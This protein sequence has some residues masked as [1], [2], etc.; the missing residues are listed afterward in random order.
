MLSGA[1]VFRATYQ[2]FT[3]EQFGFY[4][5]LWS[6]FGYSILLDFGLGF[7]TQRSAAHFTA[8]RDITRLNQLVTTV[9]WSFLGLSAILILVCFLGEGFFLKWA[10]VKPADLSEFST[11][12]RIFFLLS[13]LSFAFGI[14]PEVLQGLQRTDLVN[15]LTLV[16][17][18]VNLL[19][20]G[21]GVTEHWSF[22][23]IVSIAVATNL[24]NLGLSVAFVFLLVQGFSLH[25]RHF[26]R[27]RVAELLSFSL[28][29]YLITFTNLIL[30]RTDQVLI[31]FTLG[32]AA[33]ALYQAGYKAAEMFSLLATQVHSVLSSAA[34]QVHAQQDRRTLCQLLSR[35]TQL[36]LFFLAPAYA[37]CALYLET[38][39]KVLTGLAQ[40][41]PTTL[42][43]G[44]ILLLATFSGLVT[45]GCSRRVL[46]MCGWE[47]P[48]LRISLL[49]AVLNFSLSLALVFRLGPLGV[50]IG[51]AI[52]SLL[53]GWFF[54][55]PLSATFL[56]ISAFHWL[57]LVLRPILFPV[58]CS[59]LALAALTLGL[60]LPTTLVGCFANGVVV[61]TVLL[62]TGRGYL[63]ALGRLEQ[64]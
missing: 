34:A 7:S 27:A 30:V 6:C 8:N 17:S 64:V 14:F 49:E 12:Y 15:S 63:R 24:A 32:V 60:A 5:L 22:P 25:P 43:S 40:P 57:A 3:S 47:R 46:V 42:L 23:S 19:L 38:L 31:G 4:A 28:V 56:E 1:L 55:L 26:R 2:Y 37:L 20:I 39:V 41:S 51:T 33:V 35:G 53:T 11:A 58:T 21:W 50:A 13:G 48:I 62:L 10:G 52:P 61:L 16:G 59:L 18:T 45:N 54:Q 36:T 29:A 44:Q 9:F